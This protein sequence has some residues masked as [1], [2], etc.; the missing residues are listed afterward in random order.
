MHVEAC[1]SVFAGTTVAELECAQ[2][3]QMIRVNGSALWPQP[4]QQGSDI[5]FA[6]RGGQWQQTQIQIFSSV[7]PW[8]AQALGK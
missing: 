4:I 8:A 2:T 7:P 5:Y 1:H 6:L 3:L